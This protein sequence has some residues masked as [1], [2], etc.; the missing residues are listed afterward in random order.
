MVPI[1]VQG[2]AVLAR[3]YSNVTLATP[4]PLTSVDVEESVTEPRRRVPGS[5][6][7]AAGGTESTVHVYVAGLASTVA[8]STA[9][10]LKSCDP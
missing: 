1:A 7:L 2:G 8:P 4:V 3:A 6:M 9:R 5:A 10:T